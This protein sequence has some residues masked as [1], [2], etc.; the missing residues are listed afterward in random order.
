MA[1]RVA[2]AA[3][4]LSI[5]STDGTS[6][7]AD[8]PIAVV[9][10]PSPVGWNIRP[11]APIGGNGAGLGGTG[12]IHRRAASGETALFRAKIMSIASTDSSRFRSC[13]SSIGAGLAG[14]RGLSRMAI[15]SAALTK[16]DPESM[17]MSPTALP[18]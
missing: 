9:D 12:A 13:A 7:L 18:K 17:P 16:A 15:T 11:S 2:C 6:A 1:G 8:G 5:D 10:S 3:I 4:R 14:P